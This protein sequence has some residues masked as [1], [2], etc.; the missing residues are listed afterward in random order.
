MAVTL[1]VTPATAQA[2]IDLANGVLVASFGTPITKNDRIVDAPKPQNQR[3]VQRTTGGGGRGHEYLHR[4]GSGSEKKSRSLSRAH[5]AFIASAILN[6]PTGDAELLLAIAENNGSLKRLQ[7][8]DIAEAHTFGF[9]SL[10]LAQ[11]Q[12]H[13]EP[14]LV[15]TAS[16]VF[17][18][19]GATL[20]ITTV[21]PE[22]LEEYNLDLS[23]LFG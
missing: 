23:D 7:K 11:P 8:V 3:K 14:C 21:Y 22:D 12:A 13:K 10:D 20:F 6:T 19:K 16:I 4:G 2:A 1:P 17:C 15:R 18:V 9:K 5:S